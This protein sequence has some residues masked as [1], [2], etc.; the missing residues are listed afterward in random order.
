M[1]NTDGSIST[2]QSNSESN[3]SIAVDN[4]GNGRKSLDDMGFSENSLCNNDSEDGVTTND[5][6]TNVIIQDREDCVETN[7]DTEDCVEMNKDR[8]DCV[9]MNKDT[10]DCIHM[11]K[12]REDCIE[13]MKEKSERKKVK[14]KRFLESSD[15]DNE[16]RPSNKGLL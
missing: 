11:N 6:G 14:R 4:E 13:M 1:D 7:K 16:E 5:V 2:S 12:D 3:H 8:E 10:E 9:E 15:E